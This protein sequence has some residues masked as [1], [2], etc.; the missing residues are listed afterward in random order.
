ML[1]YDNRSG[2]GRLEGA[3]RAPYKED[4]EQKGAK[5]TKGKPEVG[6]AV[7]GCAKSGGGAR[8]NGLAWIRGQPG[9]V[10]RRTEFIPFDRQIPT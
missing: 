3:C 4:F 6:G 2:V 10:C 9:V 1:G 7:S 5:V 8:L